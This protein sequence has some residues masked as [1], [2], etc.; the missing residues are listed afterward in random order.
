[1]VAG[2][3]PGGGS[4]RHTNAASE[5]SWCWTSRVAR[6]LAMVASIFPRWRTM[7][8]SPSSRAT[9][10]GP[11]PATVAGSK[12]AKARRNPSRLRRM[13]SHDSPAWN[14]SRHSFS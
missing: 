8:A 4:N 3:G 10:S 11:K 14:P 13:V 12:P 6:A 9:S 7:A 1:M 2:G 5:P